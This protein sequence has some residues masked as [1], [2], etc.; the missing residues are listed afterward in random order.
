MCHFEVCE[1]CRLAKSPLNDDI[2]MHNVSTSR[3]LP[4]NVIVLCMP[5]LLSYMAAMS[6]EVWKPVTPL[7]PL[8]IRLQSVHFSKPSLVVVD[9][10][11]PIQVHGIDT[12]LHFSLNPRLG[13]LA[14]L[15]LSTV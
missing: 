15:D 11:F 1:F 3:E 8:L 5:N 13:S 2:C 6:V 14:S 4:Y 10:Y 7:G 9:M 12:P